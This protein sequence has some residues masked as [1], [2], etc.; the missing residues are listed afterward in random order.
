MVGVRPP[1]VL[2]DAQPGGSV[3]YVGG[4]VEG[5][6][7][8]RVVRQVV[9]LRSDGPS[10]I[11]SRR[12]IRHDAVLH[13]Q[14]P[15]VRDAAAADATVEVVGTGR[16]VAG[17]GA[18]AERQG[19]G[20]EDTAASDAAVVVVAAA[21]SGVAGDGAVAERQRSGIVEAAAVDANV[22]AA[23]VGASGI[24]GDG[25]V[26]ERQGSAVVEAAAG[27]ATVGAA[28]G[29]VPVLDGQAGDRYRCSPTMEK[30]WTALFPLI[31]TLVR[32]HR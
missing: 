17:D 9:A 26:A 4:L 20:I 7:A 2:E 29:V 28:A 11:S 15:T 23:A 8:S 22:V 14:R 5:G 13:G 1:L 16:G 6:G 3:V 12:I 10:A 24:A 25:A 19:S 27:N 21:V 31:A 18:V 30:A 32:R